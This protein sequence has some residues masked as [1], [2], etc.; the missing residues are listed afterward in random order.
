MP[1]R[2]ISN[3]VFKHGVTMLRIISLLSRYIRKQKSILLFLLSTAP[4][5]RKTTPQPFFPFSLSSCHVFSFYMSV[6]KKYHKALFSL[7]ILCG[8]GMNSTWKNRGVLSIVPNWKLWSNL[9]LLYLALFL[10]LPV[11]AIL[12]RREEGCSS[13]AT[14]SHNCWSQ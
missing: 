13:L 11:A 8:C 2:N 14:A 3:S 5:W 7:F 4:C 1:L 6:F 10:P 9:L 12:W